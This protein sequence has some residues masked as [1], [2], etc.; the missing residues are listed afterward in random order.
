VTPRTRSRSANASPRPETTANARGRAYLQ[1][2]MSRTLQPDT[3][4]NRPM[5][6]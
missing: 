6:R 5:T 2:A 3:H 4:G 1:R